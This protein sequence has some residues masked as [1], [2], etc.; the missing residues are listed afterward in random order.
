MLTVVSE[1]K[2]PGTTWKAWVDQAIQQAEREGEFENLPGKGKPLPGLGEV[3]DPDWW[4]KSLVQREKV[5]VLPPALRIKRRVEQ[6]LPR[7]RSL[8]REPD[9]RIALEK[10][11]A[12]I[13]VVNRSVTE[14]PATH[15]A[16]LDA[17]AFMQRWRMAHEIEL[18][19]DAVL[20]MHQVLELY[21]ANEWSSAERPQQLE[22]AL[23]NSDCVVSAWHGE[24]LVG[25]GNAISD[26]HLVVYYPHMLV[27]PDYQR[28]GVGQRIVQKLVERY[29]GMHQQVL[30]A[31]G[32]AIAFYERCGFTRAGKTQSMWIYSGHDH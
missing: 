2:P 21:R 12:E 32:D 9:V 8:V 3:Y 22:R 28:R 7:I 20:P 14:G 13:V 5:S 1:R 6:E 18:Q 11:N 23:A 19:V 30:M 26:G 25:L 24:R 29:R 4:T 15:I 10:L 31:D 16:P 27:R 17:D